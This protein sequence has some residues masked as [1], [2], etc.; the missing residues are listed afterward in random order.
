MMQGNKVDDLYFLQGSTVTGS[1][2]VSSDATQLWHTWLGF[3]KQVELQVEDSKGCKM[4]LK[5]SPF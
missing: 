1:V 2:D 4:A 5:L 3:S